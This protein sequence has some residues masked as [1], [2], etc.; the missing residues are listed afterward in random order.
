[1]NLY[2]VQ[3]AEAKAKEEDPER[4]LTDIGLANIK[5]VA[6]FLAQNS[7][8]HLNTIIHSGKA[9]AIQ[10]AE[11]LA[12][13][14]NPSSGLE[15]GKEL[16][17]VSSPWGWVENLSQIDN[18]IMLVGHLPHLNRLASLLLCQDETKKI[19]EFRNGG[20]LHLL[21]DESGIWTIRWM[22]IPQIIPGD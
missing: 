6:S 14:L 22:V 13:K 7:D 20:V 9:R 2:L 4:H 5:K 3:H 16:G 1:M 21:K 18:D 11:V 19:V 17:P 10:T 12:E 8:I 15:V